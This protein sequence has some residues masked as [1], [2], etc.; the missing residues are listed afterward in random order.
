[1]ANIPSHILEDKQPPQ[2]LPDNST[3][4][5]IVI[6]RLGERHELEAPTDMNLNLMEFLKACEFPVKATCGG[7]ALCSTCHVFVQSEHNLPI[8]SDAEE[9]AL[10]QSFLMDETKSRLSCQMLLRP[11][12]N[13]LVIQIAPEE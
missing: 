9:L 11:E 13:G 7:M 4:R 5:L 12:L 3:I 2:G 1:M 6:D 8:R 10:E